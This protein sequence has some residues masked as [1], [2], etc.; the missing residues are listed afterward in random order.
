M[1]IALDVL[2]MKEDG[3]SIQEARQAIDEKYRAKYPGFT[4]TPTPPVE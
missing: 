4:P 3:K 1:D 2:Q